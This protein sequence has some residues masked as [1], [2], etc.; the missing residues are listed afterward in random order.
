[1]TT[2][3]TPLDYRVVSDDP[4]DAEHECHED[5]CRHEHRRK[6]KRR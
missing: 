6:K 3:R 4:A 1:M 5:E 2:N